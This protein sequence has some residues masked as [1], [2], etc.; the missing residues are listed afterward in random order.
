MSFAAAL[1]WARAAAAASSTAVVAVPSPIPARVP[2]A[3]I[4]IPVVAISVIPGPI[5]PKPRVR[6]V[7]ITIASAAFAVV[8]AA[9]LQIHQVN[10]EEGLLI[11][12]VPRFDERLEVGIVGQHLTSRV[13]SGNNVVL[14]LI[15]VASEGICK[16]RVLL[17]DHAHR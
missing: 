5:A 8:V 15:I 1:L 10:L 11:E 4:H 6:G 2:F 7:H 12:Q 3:A 13:R 17:A 9:L 14:L 16:Q